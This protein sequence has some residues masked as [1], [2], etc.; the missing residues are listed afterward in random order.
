MDLDAGTRLGSYEIVAFI[1][2]GAMGTVY[3][4]LDTKLG[5]EVAIKILPEEFSHDP[6]RAARFEREARLLAS[7]NH[8]HIATL[9]GLEEF[10]GRKFLVM[11]LVEGETLGEQ[12]A[13]GALPIAELLP[14]F[15]QITEALEAAHEKGVVHRDL[16]PPNIKIT[17][18]GNIKVLDFGLAKAFRSEAAATDSGLSESPTMTRGTATGVILGT[19]PYMSPEQAKGKAVDRRTDI[20][21]FGCCLYEALTGKAA[22]LADSVT[23]TLAKILERDPDWDALPRETPSA[24][25]RLL[26][27]CLQKDRERRLRDIGDARFDLEEVEETT[28]TAS[29]RPDR[30]MKPLVAIAL[31]TALALGV[32]IGSLWR[33]DTR[34]PLRVTRTLIPLGPG[35]ALAVDGD[36]P[37]AIT[38]DGRHIAYSATRDQT[39]T[40]NLRPLDRLEATAILSSDDVANDLFFSDDGRWLGFRDSGETWKVPVSGGAPVSV[41]TAGIRGAS[42]DESGIVFPSNVNGGLSW[43]AANGG[44]VSVLTSPDPDHREKG[45]RFPEILPGG[46]A[47]LFTLGSADIASWD[48]AS[49]AVLSLATGEYRVVL[50]GGTHARYSPSGHL[51]YART[52]TL[53]AA[54]F[55]LDA[56]EVTGPPV[57]VL[58]GVMTIPQS[59]VAFFALTRYGSLLYAPGGTWGDDSRVVLVDR[60]GRSEPLIETPG[61]YHTPRLSPDGSSLALTLGGANDSIWIYDIARATLT[62]SIYGYDNTGPAWTPEGDRLAFMSTRSGA[63]NLFRQHAD[64]SGEAERLTTNEGNQTTGSWSRDGK[65]LVFVEQHPE[66]GLD[67][68]SLSMDGGEAPKRLL[69]EPFDEHHPT[70]APD[71]RWLAYVSNESGQNEVYLRSFPGMAGKRQVSIEG[72][73]FPL[74]SPNGR[75][76]FY[77]DETR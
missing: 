58:Q 40:L 38:P 52:H 34:G 48:D 69:Y 30:R 19:A 44:D 67:V 57:P 51:V 10:N 64:G 7:L 12:I 47:V 66:T 46:E 20:W 56:L 43:V 62:R 73:R 61:N 35:E 14:L 63:F 33:S 6:D 27:R 50:E 4:A 32:A 74:W 39:S 2:A 23:S 28:P 41:V 9:H 72:G 53:F 24:V 45:H 55:D 11:E 65:T 25:R 1:G 54:P 16:K 26:R 42:W 77:R 31:L 75:E 8:P 29:S 70:L 49:I 13:R 60:E 22:F 71:G 3:R 36:I 15:R 17:P 21:A 18:E 37:L 5:R 59:G 68:W 76:L